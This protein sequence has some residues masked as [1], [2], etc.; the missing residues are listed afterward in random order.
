MS[1]RRSS[2]LV[3]GSLVA[4]LMT[5]ACNG[6][7]TALTVRAQSRVNRTTNTDSEIQVKVDDGV[8]TLTGIASSDA[9][10]ERAVAAAR[11]AEGVRGVVD[12][13]ARPAALTGGTVPK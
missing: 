11:S 6:D 1:L 8:A 10:R 7:D 9:V 4:T 3:L 12:H 5:L 2:G 13:I